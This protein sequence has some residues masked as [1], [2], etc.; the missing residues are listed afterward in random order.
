MF[1]HKKWL[2]IGRAHHFSLHKLCNDRLFRALGW[3]RGTVW[4]QGTEDQWPKTSFPAPH[5]TAQ[6]S[7]F[8]PLVKL[9]SARQTSQDKNTDHVSRNQT[10]GFKTTYR[11]NFLKYSLTKTSF[12][13]FQRSFWYLRREGQLLSPTTIEL[14]VTWI[15]KRMSNKSFADKNNSRSCFFNLFKIVLQFSSGPFLVLWSCKSHHSIKT[16][17]YL[18]H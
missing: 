11:K 9:N 14:K 6:Q 15:S 5:K 13:S 2:L 17:F 3:V 1:W 10:R 12:W 18:L 16:S 8:V 7:C 4:V